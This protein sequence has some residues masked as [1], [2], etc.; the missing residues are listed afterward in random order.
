MNSC[1]A[2]FTLLELVVV[3]SII[4]ILA[5]LL[6][7]EISTLRERAEKVVCAGH[8]RSL[9]VALGSYLNDNEQ[10]PQLPKDANGEEMDI[11]PQDE[12]Q[13]WLDALKDYGVL[14]KDWQ[15]PTLTRLLGLNNA[16]VDTSEAPKMHY[17]PTHFDDS[18]LTPRKWP[19]MPWLIEIS[20]IHHGGA[21]LIR[22]DGAVQTEREA[23]K[24]ASN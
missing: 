7:P 22:A 4:G 6:L 23:L 16:K 14:A 12:E 10:W 13:F 1:K 21:L 2:G 9:H 3:V 11:T 20:D 17:T 19:S 5:A 15:C 8:L 18:P 24:S